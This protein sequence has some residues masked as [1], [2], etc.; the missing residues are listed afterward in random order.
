M[1]QCKH[2]I[3]RLQQRGGLFGIPQMLSSDATSFWV[4]RSQ[5]SVSSFIQGSTLKSQGQEQKKQNKKKTKQKT[6]NKTNRQEQKKT[7]QKKTNKQKNKKTP[8]QREV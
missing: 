6:K 7:K 4:G 3:S 2:L 8:H 1:Y 5:Q